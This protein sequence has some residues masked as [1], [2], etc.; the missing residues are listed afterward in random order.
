M[1]LT[2]GSKYRYFVVPSD[3][4]IVVLAQAKPECFFPNFYAEKFDSRFSVKELKDWNDPK[5]IKS[6][7]INQF[8]LIF[9]TFTDLIVYSLLFNWP[10]DIDKS[11][12]LE[13]TL[14]KNIY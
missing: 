12:F 3:C 8:C 4:I 6:S 11:L 5:H 7:I 13:I 10:Q 1:I 14:N 2:N 9:F